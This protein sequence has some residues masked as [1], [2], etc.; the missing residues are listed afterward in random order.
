[1][2][3]AY[4]GRRQDWLK[5]VSIRCV[6][7]DC[8]QAHF[9]RAVDSRLQRRGKPGTDRKFPVPQVQTNCLALSRRVAVCGTLAT[10]RVI[11]RPTL[12]KVTENVSSVPGLLGR[13]LFPRFSFHHG[14][15]M[16]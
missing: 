8:Q 13:M 4:H 15:T 11:K 2:A 3:E 7:L 5:E 1:M 12:D 9:R 6:I 10:T 16:V 14:T